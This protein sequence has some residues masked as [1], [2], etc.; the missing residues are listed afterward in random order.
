V[1]QD[2]LKHTGA[3]AVR[4]SSDRV[5]RIGCEVVLR[6]DRNRELLD[7]PEKIWK[8]WKAI[9]RNAKKGPD[10]DRVAISR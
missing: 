3:L 6:G 1:V 8:T 4:G 2:R 5:Q 7:A 9:I 10:S